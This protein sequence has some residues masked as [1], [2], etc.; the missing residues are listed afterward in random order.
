MTSQPPTM[1]PLRSHTKSRQG[2]MAC[3]ARKVKC[4]EIRPACEACLRRNISCTYPEPRR[5]P[6]PLQASAQNGSPTP[7]YNLDLPRVLNITLSQ[8]SPQRRTLE[9][10]LIHH[11]C[12]E[13]AQK[14]FLSVHDETVRELWVKRAPILAFDN[15]CLLEIIISVAALHL[16]KINPASEDMAD[17]HRTYFNA[18]ISKHRRIIQNITADNAE[19]ICLSTILIALPAFILL[20]NHNVEKYSPPVQLFSLLQGNIPLFGQTLPLLAPDSKVRAVVTAKPD[21][22]AFIKDTRHGNYLD[23]FKELMNWRSPG[24]ELNDE[25]QS[26]YKQTLNIVG[27][28]L[29]AIE[30][31][32]SRYEIRR[33]LYSFPTIAPAEF[34]GQLRENNPRALVIL[35]H[36]FSLCKAVDDVWWMRGIAERE[37]FG[38]QSIL[39]EQW[40]WAMAW[41]LQKLAEYAARDI[42]A[43]QI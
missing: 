19:A 1:R 20:Q 10:R 2:C 24:E 14:D 30:N 3:K 31:G 12:T 34:G 22:L 42:S 21:M 39:P 27:R 40:Q 25:I 6:T 15:P 28:Y 35:A 9:M 18:A 36:F 16:F 41:P 38:I 23:P 29:L 11:F 17:V 5:A 37:V 33:I 26:V 43:M 13:T 8:E 32:D 4:S 7:P